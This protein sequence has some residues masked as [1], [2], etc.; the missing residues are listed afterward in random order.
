MW[1]AK[2]MAEKGIMRTKGIFRAAL[3]AFCFL[4]LPLALAW[5][6]AA[7]GTVVGTVTDPS[8]AV[9]PG[10]QVFVTNT[11]T[12]VVSLGQTDK[13]GHFEVDNLQIGS[14]AVTVSHSG[15]QKTTTQAQTLQINQT[16]N[17]KI[18]LP[19]GASTQSVT[20]EAAVAGVETRNVTV[21]TT[22][23]G[24][25]IHDLPLNGRNVLSLAQLQPGV[26]PANPAVGG[27]SV[28]GGRPDSITY[29]LNGGMDNDLLDNGVVF[30]PNPDA[31]QE[32]RLL[33]SNYT[34]EYGRNGAGVISIEIKPG[35]N[36]YHGSAFD[37]VRN[38][39]LNANDFFRNLNGVA[40]DQLKRNQ[41]GGTIGG[42]ITIPHVVNGANKLFFFASYQGQRQSDVEFQNQTPTFT[43]AEL[44]GDFSQAGPNGGPDPSVAAFLQANP[45][46][47]L[48]GGADA[49]I[50][51]AKINPVATNFIKAGL[52]P[53][54]PSGLIN[55]VGSAQDNNNQTL[56]RVDY[57]PGSRDRFTL[58][59]GGTRERRLIPFPGGT[60]VSGWPDATTNYSYY[61]GIGQVHTFSPA[62]VNEFHF[63]V[64]RSNS[65]QDKPA[66]SLPGP[67]ALGFG[68]TPD[69]PIAPPNLDWDSGLTLGFSVQGP[70]NLVGTTWVY[71]DAVTWVHGNNSWKFGGGFSAYQQNMAFDFIGNGDYSFSAS[72]GNGPIGSGNSFADFLLGIPTQLQEGPN[73]P[74]NIR[75]KTSYGFIQDDWR[76]TNSLTWSLGLR[77]EYSTPKIDTQGREFGLLP[78]VQSQVFAN[79]PL[80]LVFPGDP[81]EPNGSNFADK[82][83]FAPRIGFAWSPG[84]SGTTSVRGGFGVFYDVL[85][86]EDNFQF[87]GQPPFASSVNSVFPAVAAGQAGPITYLSNPFAALG[88]PNP[89]PSRKPSPNLDFGAAGFL[90]FAPPGGVYVNPHIHTPYIYQ[91]N[92]SLQHQFGNNYVGE[93]NYVGSS[94]K[95]LTGEVDQNP[96]V[97]GSGSRLLN[98]AAL[99][100]S[101]LVAN[102]CK[103]T[104][105]GSPFNVA[106]V[107]PF[108]LMEG[109]DN[110]GFASFNSVEGSISKRIGG[111]TTFRNMY[112]RLSYTYGR[113]IDNSSGFRNNTSTVPAGNFSVFR[114]PSDFDIANQLQ[115]NGS[116]ELPFAQTWTSGPKSVLAGW[117]LDPILSWRT[118]FPL[119]PNAQ[120][121]P[122]GDPSQP[123]PSGLGDGFLANAAFA[124]GFTGVSILDPRF[125][126]NHFFAAGK[127]TLNAGTANECVDNGPF[128][129]CLNAFTN[130][131]YGLPRGVFRGPGATNLDLALVKDTRIGEHMNAEIRGEAFN[132]FNNVEFG[133]PSLNLNNRNFG[134][135]LA[136][137]H[138]PRIVQLAVRLSF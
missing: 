15:F 23:T 84:G 16:L 51:P 110:V 33:T 36:Q 103:A 19:L 121:N 90:P 43:P 101:S 24:D 66:A 70:S 32:F 26:T 20:V 132:V 14:Y 50:D 92:L 5:G 38:G 27:F 55:S 100:A 41:F 13:N 25:S 119:T 30:N 59:V 96:F 67:A 137:S 65:L 54:D 1:T 99:A 37:F 114:G 18:S 73:A 113:S 131:P 89:F 44:A 77:Y 81:G 74:S 42:P 134:R 130:T 76:M 78:G 22:I 46:F 124:P 95:G 79:A 83:N 71:S 63:T 48:D 105:A 12:G 28:A 88:I 72:G 47:A 107:C 39:D 61:T 35:T 34:A 8:Q 111:D 9:I 106:A 91:Y 7:T 69:L 52:I 123:G 53:T 31:V 112:F 75:Q 62:V 17:F 116:W 138:D 87:N 135:V 45:F 118:G 128:T 57:D 97:L 80:G 102:S 86:A 56:G 58:T 108:G 2:G 94:S 21:G 6:Q 29:L 129:N 122:N 10:A 85:K 40:R 109:F 4:C 127:N 120:I 133:N 49:K 93:I 117:R 3:A 68:V 125:P 60:N 82:D 115:F 98:P 104:F 136:T 126:G 11:A 64:Q